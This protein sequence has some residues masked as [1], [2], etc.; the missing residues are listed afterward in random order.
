M[1]KKPK[2][3]HLTD[4]EEL[5]QAAFRAASYPKS[6]EEVKR[7]ILAGIAGDNE[8]A[9]PKRKSSTMRAFEDEDE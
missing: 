1:A 8:N 4:P 3:I 6:F 7:G 5:R 2:I 9:K